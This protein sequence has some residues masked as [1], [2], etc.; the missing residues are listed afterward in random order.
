MASPR[1]VTIFG[2]SGFIGRAIL[3]QLSR[4]PLSKV[5]VVSRHPPSTPLPTEGLSS[6]K[7][8]C[9][10]IRDRDAVYKIVKDGGVGGH[11]VNLVG[12]LYESPRKGVGFNAVHS[13]GPKNIVQA[14]AEVGSGRKEEDKGRL[15]HVSAIGVGKEG[16]KYAESK[17][18]GERFVLNRG[19]ELGVWNVVLRPSI[20]WG[21]EDSF[22]NRFKSMARFA[23]TLPLVGGGV[24]KYQPVYVDDVARAVLVCL[25]LQMKG[26]EKAVVKSGDIYEL[27]GDKIFTFRELMELTM[28]CAHMRRLLVPVPFAVAGTIG[29][30][31]EL[32]HY[33]VPA[34]PPTLTRDQVQLLRSD[35]VVSPGS[36]GLA[37]LGIDPTPLNE[38]N[39]SYLSQT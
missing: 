10:D 36:R 28:K 7:H 14:V 8:V 12:L 2:G 29:A 13:D 30:A 37:D 21:E 27:G 22:F 11:V 31:S 6:F 5:T 26:L 33:A 15:V 18:A 39:L 1:S 24:T 38:E 34:L 9:A 19:K 3:R 23:P 35:N 32:M 4:Q 20:V 16:A 17:Y 25:G